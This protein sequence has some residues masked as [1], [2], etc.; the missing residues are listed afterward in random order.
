M[1]KKTFVLRVFS[2]KDTRI[3]SLHQP[4]PG[5]ETSPFRWEVRAD[6]IDAQPVSLFYQEGDV[7]A[8]PRTGSLIYVTVESAVQKSDTPPT[9]ETQ[10]PVITKSVPRP[11]EEG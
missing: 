9:V 7:N 8:L 4:G 10:P 11:F 2:V 5:K 1:E 6:A 3:R